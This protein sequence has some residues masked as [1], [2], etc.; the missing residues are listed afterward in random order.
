MSLVARTGL[1]VVFIILGTGHSGAQTATLSGDLLTD[2]QTQKRTM[3]AIADAMPE[4]LFGFKPT[5]AQ[6]T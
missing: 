4:E 3:L 6:R 2:W 5:D 1:I